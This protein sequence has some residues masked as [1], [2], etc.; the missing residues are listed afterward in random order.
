MA[1]EAIANERILKHLD[2]LEAQQSLLANCT[3]L[4]KSLSDHFSSLH[5]TLAGRS[6]SLD[7]DLQSLESNTQQSLDAISQRESS[8]P[9]RESAAADAIRERRDAVLAEIE[10]PDAHGPPAAN[11]LRGLLRW[12]ARRM[13]SA[14]LWRLVASRRKDLAALRR[15]MTDAVAQSV[16]PARLVIDAAEDFLSHP[17][18]DGADRNWA[19]GMLL[20]SLLESEGRKAPEVAESMKERAMAVAESWREK[21]GTKGEVEEGRGEMGGS[22]AQ[23]FLQM[24]AA[25]G[26]RSRFVEEYLKML[27]MDHASRKEMAKIATA[28]GFREQ[29]TD[30]IDELVK[31]GKEIEAVYFVHESGLSERFPP[32]SLLKSY[33]QASRKKANSLVKDGNTSSA[34]KQESGNLEISALKSII[35]CVEF[36]NLESKFSTD[37]LKKRLAL[38]EKIKA[39]KKKPV[40]SKKSQTKRPRMTDGTMTTPRPVKATRTTNTPY[41]SYSRN[42]PALSHIPQA[43]HTYGF[44]GQGGYDGPASASYAAVRSQ[45]PATVT[46]QYY[47]HDDIG[48]RRSGIPYGGPSI[49]YSGYDYKAPVPPTQP[50]YPH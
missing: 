32:D 42:P 31:S 45:S 17:S 36:C 26:L 37:G 1:A 5:Q 47:V 13:D 6:Q 40:T 11:D 35:K 25:F 19:L 16:D 34:A 49:G 27:I 12:Y 18:E 24:V 43:R 2:N 20:R 21:F 8:L 39:E 9:D 29:L 15:E 23:I 3:L 22:E 4:W 46:Q 10:L 28:L 48:A 33:L 41:A 44:P 30:V 7:A 14:G 38:L 50:S